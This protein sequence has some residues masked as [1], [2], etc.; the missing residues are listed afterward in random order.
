MTAPR[1]CCDDC[2]GDRVC[3]HS[4]V[5]MCGAHISSHDDMNEGHSAVSMHDYHADDYPQPRWPRLWRAMYYVTWLD[6]L[7]LS[8]AITV[9][10]V[11]AVATLIVP[12]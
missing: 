9:L 2:P 5:C 4:T 10:L 8:S 7:V 1:F 11:L 6:L 12:T 3:I